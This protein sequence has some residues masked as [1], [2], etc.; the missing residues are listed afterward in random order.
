M[1]LSRILEV[2]A[3]DTPEEA[4]DYDLMDH[5]EVNRKFVT[6]LLA[7]MSAQLPAQA[8]AAEGELGEPAPPLQGLDLGTGTAQIP[9]ELCRQHPTI[10]ILGADLA[11]QMLELAKYNIE[12]AGFRERI[13][14]AQVDAKGLR[15]PDAKFDVVLSNSIIHHIPQPATALAEAVRVTKPGGVLFFRDLVRPESTEQLELLVQTYT[16]SESP[17]AQKMFADSLRAALSL[18]EIQ[19]LVAALGFAAETVQLTSDRHWTW[20]TCH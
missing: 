12:A 16:G 5:R 7:F 3:M 17:A 1:T 20:A 4:L 8:I 10:Q 9:V 11:I 2:E 6:D 14:L 18:A 19:D 13:R 15:F